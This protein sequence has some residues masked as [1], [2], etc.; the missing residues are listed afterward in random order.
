VLAVPDEPMLLKAAPR[1]DES[2]TSNKTVEPVTATRAAEPVRSPS[3]LAKPVM[4]T[5]NRAASSRQQASSDLRRSKTASALPKGGAD[6]P[7]VAA[8]HAARHDP[9]TAFFPN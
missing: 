7:A 4:S 3:P 5:G 2:P 6:L 1:T 8:A 9:P